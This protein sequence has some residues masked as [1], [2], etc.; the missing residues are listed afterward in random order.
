MNATILDLL[1][2]DIASKTK[3]ERDTTL[4]CGVDAMRV[5]VRDVVDDVGLLVDQTELDALLADD[6]FIAG[7]IQ[8][9]QS[10]P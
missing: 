6:E 8:T 5:Y 2:E 1:T 10:S 7:L 4:N 3:T 9:L